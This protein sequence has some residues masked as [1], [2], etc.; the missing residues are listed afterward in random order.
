MSDLPTFL[1][2]FSGFAENIKKQPTPDQWARIVAKIEQ[3][4][5]GSAPQAGLY[6]P[7]APNPP[8]ETKPTT[9]LQWKSVFIG[10]LVEIGFDLDSAKEIAAKAVPDLALDA[11]MAARQA[12]GPIMN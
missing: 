12:A 10:E 2:W 3:I 4:D 9:P 1:A 6:A 7:A 5:P 11:K 8:V